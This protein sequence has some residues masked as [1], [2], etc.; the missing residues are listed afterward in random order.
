MD[1]HACAYPQEYHQKAVDYFLLQF[2]H[3]YGVLS[4]TV[5]LG[6]HGL[7]GGVDHGLRNDVWAGKPVREYGDALLCLKFYYCEP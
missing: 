2:H 3:G 4:G 5:E 6:F 7:T 1:Q